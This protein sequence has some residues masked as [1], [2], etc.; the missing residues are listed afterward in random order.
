METVAAEGLPYD[1]VI[2]NMMVVLYC[3]KGE[4]E[5]ALSM[6]Q[7]IRK[8]TQPNLITYNPLVYYYSRRGELAEALNII[9]EM[10][11]NSVKPEFTTYD[12]LINPCITQSRLDQ[13]VTAL[14]K[15]G[16]QKPYIRHDME[17]YHRIITAYMIE[18]KPAKAK[19]I[20]ALMKTLR[21]WPTTITMSLLRDPSY[22]VNAIS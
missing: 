8:N 16:T 17:I 10:K 11:K 21:V 15:V 22:D 5:S 19:N 3:V 6:V 2:A 7:K 20:V 9:D 1:L 12:Q 4:I 13:L 18:N 14:E